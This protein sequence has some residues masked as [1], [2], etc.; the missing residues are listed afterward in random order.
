MS[1]WAAATDKTYIGAGKRG[2][3]LFDTTHATIRQQL[4][5]TRMVHQ[6]YEVCICAKAAGLPQPDFC[7]TEATQ[8]AALLQLSLS[9]A[10]LQRR[11]QLKSPTSPHLTL[12]L[13]DSADS[14]SFAAAYCC[15]CF[16]FKRSMSSSSNRACNS[17]QHK[18]WFHLAA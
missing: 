8:Q 2:D 14:S 5:W 13:I 4:K 12:C 17:R 10:C 6:A 7:R 3:A 1:L 15:C 11:V 9:R 16:N 18:P